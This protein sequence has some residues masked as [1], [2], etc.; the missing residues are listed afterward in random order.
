MNFSLIKVENLNFLN[1]MGNIVKS[2][3]KSVAVV[4][5]LESGLHF[6]PSTFRLLE[7]II[8][9]L[10]IIKPNQNIVL[11]CPEHEPRTHMVFICIK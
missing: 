7:C 2:L 3:W 8:K 11:H 1:Y 6:W 5:E 10:Q 4:F 9:N